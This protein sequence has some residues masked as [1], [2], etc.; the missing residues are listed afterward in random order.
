MN[1]YMERVREGNGE[2]ARGQSGSKKGSER[3]EQEP[4]YYYFFK[5]G[6][7][8]GLELNK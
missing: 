4:H 5:L 7:L 8:I 2:G 1:E 3:E 6:S